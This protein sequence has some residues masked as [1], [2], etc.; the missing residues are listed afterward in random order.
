VIEIRP[1]TADDAATVHAMIQAMS[2]GMALGKTAT[3]TADDFRRHADAWAALIAWDGG[4][5]VGLC[6]HFPSFSS[7]RGR[8][9]VYI[10]DLY[11]APRARGTGLARALLAAAVRRTGAAYLRLSVDR[12]NGAARRFYE[13]EGLSPAADERIYVIEGDA[14][15]RL[16]GDER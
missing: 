14:L 12:A 8:V 1:A 5:A 13:R 16:K 10:Q 2:A 6:L 15:A 11:V 7:W 9:G 3:S 4:E